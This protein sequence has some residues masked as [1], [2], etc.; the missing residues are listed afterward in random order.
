MAGPNSRTLEAA[1]GLPRWIR[2]RDNADSD[3]DERFGATRGA[4]TSMFYESELGKAVRSLGIRTCCGDLSSY[5]SAP[6]GGSWPVSR[7]EPPSRAACNR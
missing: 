3:V 5:V 6:D 1:E 7:S 4:R 2:S